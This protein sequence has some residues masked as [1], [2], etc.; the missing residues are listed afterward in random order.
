M[1]ALPWI[2]EFWAHE[3]QLPPAGSWRNW[4]I[5]GG[6]GSGKTRAGSE[7]IRTQVEGSLPYDE[8]KCRRVALVGETYDQARDVMVFGESGIIACSPPDRRPTWEATRRRLVWP[9]GAEAKCFSAKDAEAL[10]GPQFDCAWA[11]ELAK[12]PA[13][14]AWSNLQLALRLG[15]EPRALVTTTPRN[16]ACLREILEASSTVQTQAPTEA[17]RAYLASSFLEEVRA[18][19]VA[20][21]RK[22]REELDGVLLNDA[23]GA[24]WQRES[25]QRARFDIRPSVDRIVVAVDPPAGSTGDACG[26]VVVGV[27]MDGPPI[28]WQAYVLADCSVEAGTPLKWAQAACAAAR[29]YDADR[30]VAEVNQGGAM[31]EA[32]IR[33]VDPLIAYRGVHATRGKLARAEPVAGLYEAGRVRHARGLELLEE[34]M[35][36]MTTHGYQGE[37]SP[38]RLDALVWALT[39][40]VLEPGK[41]WQA[42]RV[43]GL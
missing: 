30:I 34:Q 35:F 22:A 7:W 13:N 25:L 27:A 6:R 2:W 12:W 15:E 17:N 18:R 41:L 40:A 4:V 11:D 29:D 3:H 19:Y 23:E 8:G 32:M 24:L 37:G 39:D 16:V 36:Q 42:P 20:G 5:L 38:D 31:V 33:Q 43:R 26:I 10:R 1:R 28:D 9:N 14:D 21:S